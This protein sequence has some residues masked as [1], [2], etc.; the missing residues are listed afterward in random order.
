MGAFGVTGVIGVVGV[1][2]MGGPARA[3]ILGID[4]GEGIDGEVG[5]ECE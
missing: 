4:S 5:C 3:I 1:G 2:A